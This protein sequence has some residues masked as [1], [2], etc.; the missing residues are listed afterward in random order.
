[1]NRGFFFDI[2]IDLARLNRG[3]VIE[4]EGRKTG[5]EGMFAFRYVSSE[6]LSK[7]ASISAAMSGRSSLIGNKWGALVDLFTSCN[8]R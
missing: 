3:I 2:A 6:T 8:H 5:S 1:M 4:A 7:T